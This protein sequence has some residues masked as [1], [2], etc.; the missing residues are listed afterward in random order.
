MSFDPMLSIAAPPMIDLVTL[1][2]SSSR[3]KDLYQFSNDFSKSDFSLSKCRTTSSTTSSTTDK[4]DFSKKIASVEPSVT[5]VTSFEINRPDF[6]DGDDFHR[7]AIKDFMSLFRLNQFDDALPGIQ[8]IQGVQGFE[9]IQKIM[10]KNLLTL[11]PIIRCKS[12]CIFLTA[13]VYMDRLIRAQLL[14][15]KTNIIMCNNIHVLM[16]TS[17]MVAAKF[18]TDEPF[19]NPYMIR[20]MM[21]TW[22][23]NPDPLLKFSDFGEN[24]NPDAWIDA[25]FRMEQEFCS[26]LDWNLHISR[27]EMN[28]KIENVRLASVWLGSETGTKWL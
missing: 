11:S 21:Y 15:N 20:Q 12:N 26:I 23:E 16:F 10:F 17:L 25:F 7:A 24:P 4:F 3:D 5:S 2:D 22:F 14:Q 27:Q 28:E 13:S 18:T 8:G 1:T 6:V 19:S 9:S